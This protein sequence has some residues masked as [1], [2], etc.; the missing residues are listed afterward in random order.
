[1]LPVF[2]NEIQIRQNIEEK[3]KSES[4]LKPKLETLKD[5][6]TISNGEK[7]KRDR[8][9]GMIFPKECIFYTKE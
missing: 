5:Y 6:A 1:M 9:S 2:Y 4:N 7:E 8:R 3:E